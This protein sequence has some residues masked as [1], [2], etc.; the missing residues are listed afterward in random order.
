MKNIKEMYDFAF[1]HSD[2]FDVSLNEDVLDIDRQ[3]T[4]SPYL[5]VLWM[6]RR[7][8]KAYSRVEKKSAALFSLVKMLKTHNMTFDR[9]EADKGIGPQL[10]IEDEAAD[11]P[12]SMYEIEASTNLPNDTNTV[13][14]KDNYKSYIITT[15]R[16]LFSKYKPST[17]GNETAIII[18]DL[19]EVPNNS[20]NLPY[21]NE[22]LKQCPEEIEIELD[23]CK[24]SFR[25]DFEF[26]DGELFIRYTATNKQVVAQ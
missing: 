13:E 9:S 7:A 12:V 2:L 24:I 4:G 22:A 17:S 14:K 18:Q 8:L 25:S 16:Y 20:V 26:F 11:I 6:Y 23:Y 5:G 1:R 21:L 19:L 10:I 3:E 15:M